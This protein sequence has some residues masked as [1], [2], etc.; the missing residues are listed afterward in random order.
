MQRA[1]S[2]SRAVALS[3]G[4]LLACAAGS[5]RAQQ[6]PGGEALPAGHP[7]V[8]AAAP[9]TQGQGEGEMDGVF[10]APED[11]EEEDTARPAGTIAVEL[12]DPDD[13]PV[14][15]EVVTLGILINSIA[16]G[17]T[18]KHV[19]MTTDDAGRAI[20]S[21]L[22]MASNIAYRVSCGYQGGAFAASPFQI[23][24]GKAIHVVLHVYPVTRDIDSAVIVVEATIATELKDDRLQIEEILKVYNLG[25]AAWQP[26]DV[27]M[28]LPAGA[29]AFNA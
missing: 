4:V 27:R 12:R 7:P 21:G 11:V 13:R 2:S 19:Q 14:P 28:P 26:D 6:A 20:F 8:G 9:H 10:R 17:D 24:L 25:R 29:T 16:K 18:R 1:H 22:E 3:A 15:R 23:P 5:A